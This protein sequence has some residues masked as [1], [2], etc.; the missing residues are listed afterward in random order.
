M[1][2]MAR[3]DEEREA[4]RQHFERISEG[5]GEVPM[6][7]WYNVAPTRPR[8]NWLGHTPSELELDKAVRKMKNRKAAGQDGFVAELLKHG[9]VE[10]RKRVYKVVQKMWEAAAT[11]DRGRE[12]VEWPEEW[13]A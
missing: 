2:S 13:K 12:A 1:R 10:L 8:S 3:V 5:R 4:W 11:A 9:G 7:V 6:H